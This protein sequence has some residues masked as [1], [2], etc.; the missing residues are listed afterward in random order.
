MIETSKTGKP[1]RWLALKGALYTS[2]GATEASAS[3]T[4]RTDK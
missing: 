3:A 4:G 1:A 2:F